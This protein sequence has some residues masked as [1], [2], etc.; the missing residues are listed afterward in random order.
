VCLYGGN[1]RRRRD[2]PFHY[3]LLPQP[4]LRLLLWLGMHC[5][6]CGCGWWQL[7]F[8]RRPLLGDRIFCRHIQ[9]GLE[10]GAEVVLQG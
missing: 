9:Q 4:S 5:W 3:L 7:R 6:Y 2:W 10:S 1:Q 8:R